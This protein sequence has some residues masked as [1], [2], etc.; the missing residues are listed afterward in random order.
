MKTHVVHLVKRFITYERIKISLFGIATILFLI[1]ITTLIS[2]ESLKSFITE[3]GAWAPI[4]FIF[5]KISTI[6]LAPL[7]G[8]FIYPLAGILFGTKVGLIY[9]AIADFIGYST[10]FFLSRFLG[11]KKIEKLFEKNETGTLYKIVQM[12]GT[13]K[14]FLAAC[15]IFFPVADLLSYGSGLSRLKYRYFIGILMPGSILG[16]FVL[17]GLG[18]Y[19]GFNR[20]L[21][22][23]MI[24]IFAFLATVIGLWNKHWGRR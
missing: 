19:I 24:A 10:A 7:S 12:V 9:V 15:F 17:V 1:F 21:I 23:V 16:S 22:F 13:P 14:G 11:R 4:V 3:S 8:A 2:E 18:E 5:A 6:V 20:N